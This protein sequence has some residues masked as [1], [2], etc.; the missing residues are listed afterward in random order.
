[1][2]PLCLPPFPLERIEEM[3]AQMGGDG[4]LYV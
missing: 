1:M 2:K 4:R 3:T